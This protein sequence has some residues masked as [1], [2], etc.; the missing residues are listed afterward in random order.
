MRILLP[1]YCGKEVRRLRQKQFSV[2]GKAVLLL[3][4]LSAAVGSSLSAF[5]RA[6]VPASVPVPL[7][8]SAVPAEEKLIALTFDDGPSPHNTAR[9]LDALAERGVHATFFLVGSMAENEPALTVRIALEGHQIGIHT[10]DHDSA[11]GL[12]G[13]SDAAF[14]KQ[15]GET[16]RLLTRLTGQTEFA[17]RPPYGFV[18]DALRARAP[19]PIVL[20]SVD[21]ED[22]KYRN[23][24]RVAKHILSHVQD[25]S[26]VLL[27]DI[28]GTS[29]DAAIQVVDTL[30]AQG[31]RFV[32]VDELFSL[33]GEE[34]RRG[35]VYHSAY[36]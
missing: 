15:V 18:D 4:L 21:P 30:Q 25:G 14:D 29:V 12:R 35:G 9:L 28:F 1:Q 23:T 26:V 16:G 27:H 13:L 36:P 24:E 8:S 2:W 32:T 7:E 17:L 20:W 5:A 10:Y 22:W 3:L 34:L 11:K 33:R 31:W 6:G 19:G